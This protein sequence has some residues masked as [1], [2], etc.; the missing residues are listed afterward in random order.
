[1]PW[2]LINWSSVVWS[3]HSPISDFHFVVSALGEWKQENL[4]RPWLCVLMKQ[5][6][7]VHVLDEGQSLAKY[8]FFFFSLAKYYFFF[9]LAKCYFYL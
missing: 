7:R 6:S 2:T 9:S 5:C 4:Q 1:M 8:Y 3:W